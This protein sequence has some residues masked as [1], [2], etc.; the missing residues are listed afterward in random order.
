[1]KLEPTFRNAV[2]YEPEAIKT[3]GRLRSFENGNRVHNAI[4]IGRSFKFFRLTSPVQ[5]NRILQ[6][7]ES[8]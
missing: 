8:R 4:S 6:L 5:W 1:M 7:L 3:V 2:D